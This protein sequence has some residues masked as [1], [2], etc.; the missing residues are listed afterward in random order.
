MAKLKIT[1]KDREDY[2]KSQPPYFMRR[3]R[4]G[5][6]YEIGDH[7]EFKLHY[8]SP[9]EKQTKKALDMLNAGK[10][11]TELPVPS[12]KW[13]SRLVIFCEKHGRRYFI[14]N[15]LQELREIALKIFTER[16]KEKFWYDFSQLK[17]KRTEILSE[18][19]IKALPTEKL[20]KTAREENEANVRDERY[21]KELER[22][23]KMY[24]IILEKKDPV[25]AL[26]F[27]EDRSSKNYEYE[28]FEVENFENTED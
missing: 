13:K 23:K 4:W 19:Q 28:K 14:A 8:A 25:V 24:D 26:R 20:R 5:F 22:Q 10:S 2:N 3:N 17:E 1:K 9:D 18:D 11:V 6:G 15:N 16:R 27:I 21:F 12:D 7:K